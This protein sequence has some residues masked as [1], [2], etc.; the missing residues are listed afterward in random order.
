MIRLRGRM[1]GRE[2]SRDMRVTLPAS[3]PQ[4]DV[5]AS[6]WARTRIDDLMGQDY[7]GMQSGT[8]RT[9]FARPSRNSASTT[10]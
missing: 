2:F 1:A 3:E 8:T 4:H 5:L 10:A 7:G 6:L 9:D